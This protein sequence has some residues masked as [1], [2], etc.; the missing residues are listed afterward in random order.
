L[1]RRG[2]AA[3][4]ERIVPD[5]Y[6]LVKTRAPSNPM[7]SAPIASPDIDWFVGSKPWYEP[8]PWWA[9]PDVLRA[10]TTRVP[11]TVTNKVHH[12]ERIE[13][14]FARSAR[15]GCSTLSTEGHYEH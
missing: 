15:Q 11:T 9:A 14:S 4:E 10:V 7:A 2:V 5:P 1:S 12:V 3:I 13:K 8:G 6:S